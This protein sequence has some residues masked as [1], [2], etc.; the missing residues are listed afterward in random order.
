MIHRYKIT[1][2]ASYQG[3]YS[4]WLNE[5]QLGPTLSLEPQITIANGN[6]TRKVT[7]RAY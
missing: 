1:T 7:N 6:L 5:G 4:H 3:R 2:V